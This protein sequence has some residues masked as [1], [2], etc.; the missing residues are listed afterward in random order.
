MSIPTLPG[1]VTSFLFEKTSEGRSIHTLADYRNYLRV[2][3]TYLGDCPLDQI[4]SDDLYKFMNYMLNEYCVVRAGKKTAERISPKTAANIRSILS[5]FWKW[6]AKSYEIP[7]PYALKW[8][9]AAEVPIEPLTEAE[10]TAMLRACDE[11]SFSSRMGTNY[12]IKRRTRKRDR[13][14]IYAL[15]DT[16]A[17]ASELCEAKI[18]DLDIDVGRL[19]VSGKGRKTRFVYLGRKGAGA[20]WAYLIERYPNSKT[21]P[22]SYLLLSDD[23]VDPLNR[24][25]LRHLLLR[26]GKRAQVKNPHPHRWRHTFAIEYLR[27]GGD[28]FTLKNL[29]GHTT[30]TMVMRYVGLAQVDMERVHKKANPSDNWRIR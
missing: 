16:G 25:S 3:A 9:R 14:V 8:V 28:V 1:A 20:V 11:S 5:V 23:G 4:S 6:S 18:K 7:N 21:D 26:I 13:A 2:F 24:D 19:K 27:N 22:D 29:L 17:R 15:L 10:V 30:L 12:A